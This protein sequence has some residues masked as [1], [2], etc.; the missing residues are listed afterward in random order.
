MAKKKSWLREECGFIL[1]NSVP[2]LKG[3]DLK[4]AQLII[5]K[6]LTKGLSKTTQGVAIWIN[7]QAEFPSIHLPHSVWHHKD[8]LNR[9]EVSRL[10]KILMET[11]AATSQLNDTKSEIPAKGAWTTKLQFAWDVVLAGLVDDSLQTLQNQAK[12]TKRIKFAEFWVE[13]IDSK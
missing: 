2:I 13:C 9:K 5:D 7:I 8:P 6:L 11:P 12:P 3:K 10:V 1:F 4:Y